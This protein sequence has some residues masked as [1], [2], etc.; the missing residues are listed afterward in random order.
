MDAEIAIPTLKDTISQDIDS[1]FFNAN[2]FCEEHTIV[3]DGETMKLLVQVDNYE[4]IERKNLQKEYTD[5][6]YNKEF[7]IY[8]KAS[9]FG[10]MPKVG[11]ELKLDKT[12]YIVQECLEEMGVYSITLEAKRS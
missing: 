9:E 4:L 12:K 1:V 8:V 5:G 3:F 6:V 10:K 7:V 11:S 2:E